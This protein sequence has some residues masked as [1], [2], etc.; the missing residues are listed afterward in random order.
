VFKKIDVT[1]L[2]SLRSG[3]ADLSERLGTIR[4]LLNNA[5]NDQ[6]QPVADVTP[7]SW[8]RS[9]AV[10]LRHQ[11]FAAQFVSD[12]MKAAGGS[13]INF[14]SISWMIK[15]VNLSAYA[16]SKAAVHGLTRSLARELG[17]W[18]IRVNTLV[19]GWTM[20]ERQIS[21]HLTDEGRAEISKR[22]CID[23]PLMP[24]DIARL[25]LFLASEDSAMCTG[26]EF[27]VDAG[28]A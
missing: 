23:K 12:G 15:M 16:S 2:A 27:I 21:D 24:E 28:W 11:F 25:A 7:E 3:I 8:D 4:V 5:A 18:G 6:R 22:Q 14:G 10:N 26:Q 13:I 20:T 1:D 17:A 9:I 19:P